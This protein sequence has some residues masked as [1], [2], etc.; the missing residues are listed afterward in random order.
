MLHWTEVPREQGCLFHKRG[1]CPLGADALVV[2]VF[3]TPSIVKTRPIAITIGRYRHGKPMRTEQWQ[4]QGISD[5]SPVA[6][7]LPMLLGKVG[8][9][10]E[11]V[12]NLSAEVEQ[13]LIR[14]S[15]TLQEALSAVGPAA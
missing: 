7:E 8:V 3:I 9:R 2:D 4:L 1:E 11:L 12:G 13:L 5:L 14:E 6:R 15:G 10:T